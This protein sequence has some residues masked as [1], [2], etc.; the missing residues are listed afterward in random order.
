MAQLS[1]D[2]FAF[3]GKL[4]SVDAAQALIAER[5][6]PL[7]GAESAALL[8]ALGRV[9][10]EDLRAPLPLPPF[11]NS[12]VDGYAFRHGDLAATGETRLPVVAR[13]QA[14]QATGGIARPAGPG[15]SPVERGRAS[16]HSGRQ[17]G[18]PEGRPAKGQRLARAPGR[19]MGA[20]APG[21][22]MTGHPHRS[23]HPRQPG[24]G[25]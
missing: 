25:R 19:A 18:A 13:L 14:G 11:F 3:G 24:R 4:M 20:P 17:R 16:A 2:C 8:R 23:G 21:E 9:L 1:D 5:V 12:A 22:T 6:P 15:A 10:A 7:P